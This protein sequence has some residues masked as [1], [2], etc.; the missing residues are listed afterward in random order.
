M[1]RLRSLD[2]S[3]VTLEI[4]ECDCGYHF[5]VDASFLDQVG[6]FN[7]IC[8]SCGELIKTE[9]LF[10]EDD[11][12]EAPHQTGR[13]STTADLVTGDVLVHP[14]GTKDT[15]LMLNLPGPGGCVAQVYFKRLYNTENGRHV[16]QHFHVDDLHCV[17]AKTHKLG[18]ST[19][20]KI[21]AAN[22]AETG[23]ENE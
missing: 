22:Q 23:V 13:I 15:V 5:G 21:E 2:R 17:E 7:F 11:L 14:D 12:K 4:G 8:P 20:I 19:H 1:R 16:M 10:N 6:D 9:V 3:D 18:N